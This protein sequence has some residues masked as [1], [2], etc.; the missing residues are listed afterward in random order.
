MSSAGVLSSHA[1]ASVKDIQPARAASPAT[2]KG[3]KTRNPVA[4][5]SATPK[6]MLSSNS[7]SHHPFS[8]GAASGLMVATIASRTVAP[9]ISRRMRTSSI[10]S[11]QLFHEHCPERIDVERFLHEADPR[12]DVRRLVHRLNVAARKHD[13]HLRAQRGECVRK[14]DAI[15]VRQ[16]DIDQR[17]VDVVACRKLVACMLR[18]RRFDHFETELLDC[19]CDE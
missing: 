10:S 13:A 9:S 2:S 15:A 1:N 14:L 16:A 3:A 11:A 7:I 12:I 4:A 18:S 8:L 19:L 6:A 17:D 5:A